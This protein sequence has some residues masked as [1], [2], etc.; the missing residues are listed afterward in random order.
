V[1]LSTLGTAVAIAIALLVVLR[2]VILGNGWS[3]LDLLATAP[4][5]LGAGLVRRRQ[6]G[7]A[8]SMGYLLLVSGVVVLGLAIA[9]LAFAI[10]WCCP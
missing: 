6:G 1:L 8:R 9:V 10:L 4:V 3:G 2:P 5:L 7:F